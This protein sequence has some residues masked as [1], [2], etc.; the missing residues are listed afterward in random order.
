[1]ASSPFPLL[2]Y[3]ATVLEDV[4]VMAKGAALNK[5]IPVPAAL[6]TSAFVPRAVMTLLMLGGA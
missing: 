2:D 3:I 4:S 5:A 6:L 1:M